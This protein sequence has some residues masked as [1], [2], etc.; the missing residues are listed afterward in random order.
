MSKK[1]YTFEEL[2]NKSCDELF[3]MLITEFNDQ[4]DYDDYENVKEALID[5]EC[6]LSE[7]DFERYKQINEEEAYG[8]WNY[9]YNTDILY[10]WLLTI[11]K[12]ESYVVEFY[13]IMGHIFR[14][15]LSYGSNEYAIKPENE[16]KWKELN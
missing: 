15:I 2:E 7:A 11:Q 3:I 5:N 13:E 10:K 14:K 4:F 6:S 12:D 9:V 1:S 8:L 16:N